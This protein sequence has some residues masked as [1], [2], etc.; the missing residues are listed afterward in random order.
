MKFVIKLQLLIEIKANLNYCEAE[1]QVYKKEWWNRVIEQVKNVFAMIL[2]RSI[3]FEIGLFRDLWNLFQWHCDQLLWTLLDVL[4]ND[5]FL[6]NC[7]HVCT[8]K[9][10]LLDTKYILCNVYLMVY[11]KRGFVYWAHIIMNTINF[12]LFAHHN[13]TSINT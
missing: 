5:K 12:Y 8:L 4:P 11:I 1:N 2:H 10:A 13:H 6:D 3:F 9:M 7:L